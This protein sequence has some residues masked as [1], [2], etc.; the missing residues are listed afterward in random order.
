MKAFADKPVCKYIVFGKEVGENGT[1]HLQGYIEF[2]SKKTMKGL[3]KLNDRAHWEVKYDDSNP[4]EASDYCKKGEQPKDEWEKEGIDGENYGKNA[5]VFEAGELSTAREQNGRKKGNEAEQEK[6]VKVQEMIQSKRKWEEVVNDPDP[7]M[8]KCMVNHVGWCRSVFQHKKK[9]K[10]DLDVDKVGFKWQRRLMNIVDKDPHPRRIY[11]YFDKDGNRGKSELTR[12]LICNHD[13]ILLSN[14]KNAAAYQWNGER[15]CIWDFP[16][17][18]AEVVNY[19]L[20]ETVKNGVVVNEKY[21]SGVKVFEKPH[22]FIFANFE[23][24]KA[25]FSKD[26]LCVIS[27]FSDSGAEQVFHF[28]NF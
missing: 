8:K 7:D 9:P 6:Y 25:K 21:E 12:H 3:K 26:R 4:K 11:W 22:V 1:P 24:D 20:I 23:P 15:V 5:D 16:R 2:A 28:A 17:S 19:G 10:F 13:G 27:D 18:M 14:V